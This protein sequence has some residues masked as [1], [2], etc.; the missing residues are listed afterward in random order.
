MPQSGRSL[1]SRIMSEL[2]VI[3]AARAEFD[4]STTDRTVSIVCS[5]YVF[6]VFLSRAIRELAAVAPGVRAS[7]PC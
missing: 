2:S 4:P 3:A 1:S 7:G 6:L 5:D